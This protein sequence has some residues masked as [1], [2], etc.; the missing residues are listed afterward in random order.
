MASCLGRWLG[1]HT[2]AR[3]GACFTGG[4]G[5]RSCVLGTAA[6]RVA[7]VML[8]ERAA[9]SRM[10]R[11]MSPRKERKCEVDMVSLSSRRCGYSRN[12]FEELN[13]F[14]IETEQRIH[15]Y[16]SCVQ[17]SALCE[18]AK[19]VRCVVRTSWSNDII[20]YFFLSFSSLTYLFTCFFLP[21]FPSFIPD[22]NVE[23]SSS[24]R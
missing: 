6:E 18:T 15:I 3:L 11:E 12:C 23:Q 21:Y 2:A 20:C 8:R 9:G 4:G 22:F 16:N 10:R 1:A 24:R 19:E 5:V 7:E 17:V 14:S 13:N